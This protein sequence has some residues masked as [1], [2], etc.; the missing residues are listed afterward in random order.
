MIQQ[1]QH[2]HL[3]DDCN[4]VHAA[5]RYAQSSLQTAAYAYY[6]SQRHTMS[7]SDGQRSRSACFRVCSSSLQCISLPHSHL[8]YVPPISSTGKCHKWCWSPCT[9][10]KYVHTASATG[11]SPAM[12]SACCVTLSWQTAAR[13]FGLQ[14]NGCDITLLRSCPYECSLPLWCNSAKPA[15]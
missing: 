4:N 5:T 10:C 12:H 2:F 15:G 3:D 7:N 14:G 11:L 9:C 13:T 6:S 1:R 8:C